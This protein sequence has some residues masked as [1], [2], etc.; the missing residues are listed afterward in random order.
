MLTEKEQKS[1]KF[2]REKSVN[3]ED[4]S[5]NIKRQRILDY[6]YKRYKEEWVK[7]SLS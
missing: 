5:K 1:L 4:I 7:P 6:V 3:F 2:I